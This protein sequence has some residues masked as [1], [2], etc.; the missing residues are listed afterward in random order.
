MSM[1][2]DPIKKALQEAD[3]AGDFGPAQGETFRQ[4]ISDTFRSQPR[5][6]SVMAWIYAL[7]FTAVAVVAAVKFFGAEGVRNQI[8]WA[9]VFLTSNM[10]VM[11]LKVW[12]WMIMNRNRILREVKR[13]ELRIAE[14]TDTVSNE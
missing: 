2:D 10:I 8:L 5:W 4:M 11:I 6:M 9:T 3:V 12:F 13:L 1:Q 7:L 14:L